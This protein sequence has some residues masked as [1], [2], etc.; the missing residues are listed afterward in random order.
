MCTHT[1]DSVNF[2][3]SKLCGGHSGWLN[4]CMCDLVSCYVQGPNY[5]MKYHEMSVSFPGTLCH[6]ISQCTRVMDLGGGM[7][8]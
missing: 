6:M 8:L 2:Y 1:C 3:G 7:W 4:D 5:M